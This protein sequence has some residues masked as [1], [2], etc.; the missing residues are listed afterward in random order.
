MPPLPVDCVEMNGDMATIPVIFEDRYE[1]PSIGRPTKPASAPGS[2]RIKSAH[3]DNGSAQQPIYEE[4]QPQV[5][6]EHK[7][8]AAGWRGP[9]AE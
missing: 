2:Q 7:S 9:R 5:T 1:P 3:H 6:V 4:I 8:K